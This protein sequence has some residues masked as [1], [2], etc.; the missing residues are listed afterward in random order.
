[1][2]KNK[3]GSIIAIV[4]LFLN[5]LVSIPVVAETYLPQDPGTIHED[6]TGN[7]GA[8]GIASQFH[9]FS[10]GKTTINAHTNGNIAT[11]EL[12]ANNNFGTDIISGDLQLEI[13]YVQM[14]DSLIG[15]SLTSGNDNRV[16][17]FVVGETVT[18][19][20]ENDKAV[21]NGSR[22][23]HLTLEEFY[24]DRPGQTYID[25]ASEFAQL[26]SSSD[27]LMS[28]TPTQTFT[29]ADFPDMNN[30][31]MVLTGTDD[32]NFILAN[33]DA[34]VL[35]G[36]TPL[37]ISNPENKVVVLNV[38]N[39]PA[40]FT[41]QS[42]IH[43]NGRNNQET[44]DFSDANLSWNFGS[45]LPNLT[46]A[47]PFQ[48]TIIAPNTD[49]TVN[50][51]M[52]GTII[53]NNVVLNASTNRW[54]PNEIFPV[55][56]P[57][58]SDSSSTTEPSTSDSTSES[59]TE[60]S[61]SESSTTEPSTSD[62]TSEST[63]E[64]STSDST[65]ESTSESSTSDSTSESTTE[66]STSDS[67]SSTTEPST[68]ESTSESTTEPSTSESTSESTTEPSTSDSTSESTTEPSTSDSTSS[69]TE[70]STSESTSE[71]TTEPSTPDSTSNTTEPST[72]DSTSEST[73][74]TPETPG[75]P[76]TSGSTM[77]RHSNG[78][79]VPMIAGQDSSTSN[80]A[81][82]I[83][84]ASG[85]N[86]TGSMDQIQNNNDDS[87]TLPKTNSTSNRWLAAVG[88]VVIIAVSGYLIYRRKKF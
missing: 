66:P 78:G 17:K 13:N 86:N 67:T 33:V 39:A 3:S 10:K 45:S 5:L 64:P 29:S 42:Q 47:A 60:P 59:T 46:I 88:I 6:L 36:N 40:D 83:L 72:S 12:D 26:V 30:R 20:A 16:N 37:N 73:P 58:H 48:G 8:L 41:V 52:D 22:I 55:D 80:T 38:I 70:P 23:D 87:T 54:D 9:V 35:Q 77:H 79:S 81:T 76:G 71:S 56:I 32:S 15:S 11:K 31:T 49:I 7:Y 24:Q 19:G 61:T 82:E 65:S 34:S 69:T 28:M 51:N 14:T 53:G 85:S 50:Q 75:T 1:M 68:S 74:E 43:Y 25:F 18:T 57:D 27:L 62:S 2:V 4:A 63:T 44:E 84:A 21:I